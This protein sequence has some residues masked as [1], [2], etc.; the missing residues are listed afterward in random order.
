MPI[1]P[2]QPSTSTRPLYPSA[3]VNTHSVTRSS[4]STSR[5][6]CYPPKPSRK[7]NVRIGLLGRAG[8]M[9]CLY[10]WWTIEVSCWCIIS[11]GS[12]Y[13]GLIKVSVG[14]WWWNMKEIRVAQTNKIRI[15][16]FQNKTTSV[17]LILLN[18]QPPYPLL[19][20]VQKH[21]LL[22]RAKP[23]ILSSTLV[24]PSLPMAFLL[25]LL[26]I[27]FNKLAVLSEIAQV[28]IQILRASSS[29]QLYQ[30]LCL[31]LLKISNYLQQF[32]D[33]LPPYPP[34]SL[35]PFL[36]SFRRINGW[37]PQWQ[38]IDSFLHY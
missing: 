10:R 37:S 8:E 29:F 7:D 2:R 6:L 21:F 35:Y 18:L 32:R 38:D 14:S 25:S 34:R 11:K 15:Q 24:Y 4:S 28:Y 31:P 3:R 13:S 22:P 30:H 16:L 23:R 33:I 1:T 27:K 5:T 36:S 20:V 17:R 9:L 19:Q 26:P 12:D